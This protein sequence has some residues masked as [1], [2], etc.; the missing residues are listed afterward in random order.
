MKNIRW[1]L[2]FYSFLG[3]AAL[4][5]LTVLMGLINRKDGSQ[6]CKS[7]KVNVE[8][9]ETFI[10]QQDISKMVN[11]QFGTI[12]GKQLQQIKYQEIEEAIKKLP[13]VSSAV[14]HTDMDGT[15][16]VSVKQ[17]EVILRVI[18]S[19]GREF[20]VD[21]KGHKIPV[22]LK[23]V[24]HVLVANGKIRESYTKALEPIE[25]ETVKD[26]VKIVNHVT[27]ND[28]WEN[29]IVQIYVNDQNDIELIPRVGKELLVIGSADSLDYKLKRLEMYYKNIL[30][31]VGTEAYAKVNV[32]YGGQIICERREGWYM[33]SLQMKINM[34]N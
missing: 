30:P 21:T 1:G 15:V 6:V 4:V 11:N 31:K 28:L 18:N 10:D 23:Y 26:L 2:V 25:T 5:G 9:K 29:Q 8:G 17:R 34:K 27:G 13:Y 19:D 3:I 32:K 22:T 14:I 33:D 24:P 20:Y 12:V 7:L 16:T